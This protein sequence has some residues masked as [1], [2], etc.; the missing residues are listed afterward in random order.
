MASLCR[1]SAIVLETKSRAADLGPAR[2]RSVRFQIARQ[3]PDLIALAFIAVSFALLGA[4]IS[5]F[6]R[7]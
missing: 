5:G 6:A 2:A 1:P 3:M 4:L 7:L